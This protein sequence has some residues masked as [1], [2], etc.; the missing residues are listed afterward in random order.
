[1]LDKLRPI[2]VVEIRNNFMSRNMD[3]VFIESI[4]IHMALQCLKIID[5]HG[6][7]KEFNPTSFCRE[8]KRR[9]KEDEDIDMGWER[10]DGFTNGFWVKQVN[11]YYASF[12]VE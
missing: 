9:S 8:M 11:S 2:I 3:S 6:V 5:S 12:M 1:M 10:I 4:M 7:L